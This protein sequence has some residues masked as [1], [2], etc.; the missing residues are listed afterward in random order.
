MKDLNKVEKVVCDFYNKHISVIK[1]DSRLMYDVEAR[2]FIW[3]FMRKF[4][5][6]TYVDMGKRYNRNH[7]TVRH[8]VLNVAYYT[9]NSKYYTE[10][11]NRI[12]A[13]IE[14]EA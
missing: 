6:S 2:H 14:N 4:Y 9:G 10:K 8:G 12:K 5:K 3:Y 7:A 11:L 1:S 13:M